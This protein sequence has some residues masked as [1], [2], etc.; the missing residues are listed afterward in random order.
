MTVLVRTRL[1]A[2]MFLFYASLGAWAVTTGTYLLEAP[3]LG[4][5][6]F[7][8]GQVGWIYSTYALGGML[9]NPIVGLLADRLFPAQRVLAVA[10]M[11]CGLMLLAAGAWCQHSSPH[12][13]QVYRSA[14]ADVRVQ[15]EPVLEYESRVRPY[16]STL[17]PEVAEELR[18]ALD[19]V[20]EAPA[21]RAAAA[22][23]FLPLFLIMLLESIALHVGLTLTTVISLRNLPDP[24]HEFS[25]TRMWGTVGWVVV[26]WLLGVLV[27]IRSP[28]PFYLA[29]IVAILVSLY[30]LT[31]P[32]T[33]P[34]GHGKT[35]REAF[36]FPAF[37]LFRDRS[38]I[39][40]VSVAWVVAVFNQFY[41]VYGHKM[42][43]DMKIPE[44]ERWMTLGQIVEVAVMF[45]IPL[46]SP[47]R[48]MKWLMLLGLLGY[49]LRG[50]ALMVGTQAW[51]IG[52][53]IP[54]HGWSFAFYFIVAA[55]YIDREAPPHLRASAQAIV[56]FIASGFGPWAGNML[57][58]YFVDRHRVGETVDW[59]AVWLVPTIGSFLV[60]LAFLI[61]FQPPP[62]KQQAQSTKA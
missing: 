13:E 33:P 42:L 22:E 29:G 14:A 38:F 57:A 62:E 10:S 20:H 35:L 58:A 2:M 28:E 41:G 44:P 31:L 18:E 16:K 26:G 4:G 54:M 1:S 30:A 25:R 8:T 46:L 12:V 56:S 47:K 55:T 15:G 60:M 61:L 49:G 23:T 36:G 53:A 9:A 24:A 51:A 3:T 48:T 37:R 5:L 39:V 32:H 21:V 43:S 27:N 34:R 19:R 59:P 45:A 50:I 17:P 7:A 52:L 40:F 11:L 6:C